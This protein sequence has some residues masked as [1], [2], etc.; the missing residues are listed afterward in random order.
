MP[1]VIAN[2]IRRGASGGIKQI[3]EALKRLED[4]GLYP[5]LAKKLN[6]S[7]EAV[8][9]LKS[10]QVAEHERFPGV[11]TGFLSFG[12]WMA[13]YDPQRTT[14]LEDSYRTYRSMEKDHREAVMEQVNR[15]G[16]THAG[17]AVL[18]EVGAT[19]HWVRI[20]PFFRWD[21]YKDGE[22]IAGGGPQGKPGESAE[23]EVLQYCYGE[24]LMH[25]RIDARGR[26]I[27][28]PCSRWPT[29]RLRAGWSHGVGQDMGLFYTPQMWG[30]GGWLGEVNPPN[31]PDVVLFHELVHSTRYM[32]GTVNMRFVNE[33]Y[34]NEEELLAIILEWILVS[35]KGQTYF[36]SGHGAGARPLDD[37]NAGRIIR[38][39]P[40]G[41]NISPKEVL[42]DFRR[43][44]QTFFDALA[45]IGPKIAPFNLAREYSEW[46]K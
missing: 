44:Q 26:R 35:E 27:V 4:G 39:N 14:P 16:R 12:L 10:P 1:P 37:S 8:K 28:S 33:G 22:G 2:A 29:L 5:D 43:G 40:Q 21:K 42:E 11:Q 13:V 23:V 41:L 30:P 9:G 15:L 45:R 20:N 46:L 32:R 31:Y 25:G 38:D 34:D 18:T 24:L 36:R 7:D 19:R 6:L 3:I 17:R